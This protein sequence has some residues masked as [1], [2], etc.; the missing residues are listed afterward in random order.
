MTVRQLTKPLR[1]LDPTNFDIASTILSG[2]NFR[3]F[4]T[5]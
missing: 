4:V 2:S 5:L 3:G 1:M